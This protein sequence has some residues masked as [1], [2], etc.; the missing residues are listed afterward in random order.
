MRYKEFIYYCPYREELY[1]LDDFAHGMHPTSRMS[2]DKL[3]EHQTV[4]TQWIYVGEL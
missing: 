4:F 1:V 3:N 2:V